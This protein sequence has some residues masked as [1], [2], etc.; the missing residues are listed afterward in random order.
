MMM[1]SQRS[2]CLFMFG[3]TAIGAP[4]ILDSPYATHAHCTWAMG[5]SN[6]SRT[7]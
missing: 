7:I 4:P 6:L 1:P 5:N 3:S 2:G